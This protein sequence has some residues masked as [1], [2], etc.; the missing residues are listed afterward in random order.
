MHRFCI[1]GFQRLRRRQRAPFDRLSQAVINL[2]E[3]IGSADEFRGGWKFT[4]VPIIKMMDSGSLKVNLE[5][6]LEA[7]TRTAH[8]HPTLSLPIICAAQLC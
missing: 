7:S 1:M 6:L 3:H 4:K 8:R 5:I 2:S